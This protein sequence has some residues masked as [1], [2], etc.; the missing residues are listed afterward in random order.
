[1]PPDCR[2]AFAFGD[3]VNAEGVNINNGFIGTRQFAFHNLPTSE[4]HLW[5]FQ[6]TVRCTNREIL[7][8]GLLSSPLDGRFTVTTLM[9][10]TSRRM[11]CISTESASQSQSRVDAHLVKSQVV[12]VQD[13]M[14]PALLLICVESNVSTLSTYQI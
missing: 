2:Y 14:S 11:M 9:Y 4:Y 5:F 1:M 13:T 7:A 6:W 10:S 3:K 8:A 12:A